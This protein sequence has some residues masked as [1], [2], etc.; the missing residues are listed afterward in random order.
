M[1]NGYELQGGKS[2]ERIPDWGEGGAGVSKGGAVVMKERHLGG[3][4][5]CRGTMRDEFAKV[6]WGQFVGDLRG[7]LRRLASFP[8]VL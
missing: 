2:G 4:S 1:K 7:S 3:W 8:G 5:P 6:S